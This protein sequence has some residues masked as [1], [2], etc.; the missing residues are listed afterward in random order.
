MLARVGFFCGAVSLTLGLALASPGCGSSGSGG[1]LDGSAGTGGGADSAS[2]GSSGAAG[3]GGAAGSGAEAGNCS[4]IPLAA[5]GVRDFDAKSIVVSGAVFLDGAPLPDQASSRGALWFRSLPAGERVEL[6][7]E[8]TGSATYSL[9]LAPGRYAVGYAGIAESC[10]D[11]PA[12]IFPCNDATVLEDVELV[13]DGNLDVNIPTAHVSGAITVNTAPMANAPAERGQLVFRHGDASTYAAPGSGVAGPASYA[14]T[15]VAGSYDIEWNGNSTLCLDDAA[16][17]VPCNRGTLLQDIALS[18][19]G[20][21]DV[22]VPMVHVT[23]QVRVNGS[24]MPNGSADRGSI[25]FSL[26]DS[27]LATK[28]FGSSG[29][30]TYVASLLPATYRV[31]WNG[32]EATCPN[33]AGPAAPCNSGTLLDAIALDNDGVLDIDVPAATVT[34]NVTIDGAPMS[35]ASAARGE[36]RFQAEAEGAEPA[37][38]V[39]FGP[40]GAGTFQTTLLEA[41]YRVSWHGNASLCDGTVAPPVPCN[42]GTVLDNLALGGNGNVDVDVSTV[43]VQGAVTVNGSPMSDAGGERGHLSFTLANDDEEEEYAAPAFGATGPAHY[44]LR[45][46]TGTYRVDF[47]GE[48]ARCVDPTPAS[49]PCNGAVLMSNLALTTSGVLDLD[50]PAITLQGAVTLDGTP[51]P[52]AS[53]DRGTLELLRIG[54]D[55]VTTRAFQTLGAATYALTVAPG[56]YVVTHAANSA[57]CGTG[58]PAAVPC[59]DQVLAGCAE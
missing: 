46:I 20:V 6:E 23:G 13:V 56:N 15:L 8:S 9:R 30:A 39:T 28:S 55:T 18:A 3:Q 14:V 16:P 33:L 29:A 26:G 51:M 34:G 36:L 57:L 54:S 1:S 7:L 45:L 5:S 17:P 43:V 11:G 19:T 59:T 32:N 21:V 53:L 31:I 41:T 12:P 22:D 50:A 58:A 24:T 47:H 42:A 37:T 10:L 35:S 49:V 52:N 4:G 40:S 25:A 38:V 48:P 27:T 44:L 2:G